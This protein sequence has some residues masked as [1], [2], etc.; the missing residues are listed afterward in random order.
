MPQRRH[1]AGSVERELSMH[2]SSALCAL[3]QQSIALHGAAVTGHA[4]AFRREEQE[5]MG[6]RI[7]R[8]LLILRF[9]RPC[10]TL[11]DVCSSFWKANFAAPMMRKRRNLGARRE[12]RAEPR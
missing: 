7:L 1:P 8:I 10:S 9:L 4:I 2:S 5:N 3:V 6:R 12:E 11:G